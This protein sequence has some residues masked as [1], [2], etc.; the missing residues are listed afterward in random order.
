MRGNQ[1]ALPEVVIGGMGKGLQNLMV[2]VCAIQSGGT[3]AFPTMRYSE[4]T[5]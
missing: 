1:N 2:P 3:P 4:S 5:Y